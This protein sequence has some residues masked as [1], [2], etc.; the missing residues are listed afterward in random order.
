ML[1]QGQRLSSLSSVVGLQST[2][3]FLR[4]APRWREPKTSSNN[5]CRYSRK[6]KEGQ[7]EGEGREGHDRT[8]RSMIL[9][10]LLQARSKSLETCSSSLT[11][12]KPHLV[13]L[14][15]APGPVSIAPS[16]YTPNT[17]A[18]RLQLRKRSMDSLCAFFTQVELPCGDL[19]SVPRMTVLPHVGEPNVIPWNRFEETPANQKAQ[20]GAQPRE[21]YQSHIW[22]D[23]S[24]Q[25]HGDSPTVCSRLL[26]LITRSRAVGRC[27]VRS[28]WKDRQPAVKF[29]VSNLVST[30]TSPK[31]R[32]CHEDV[33][34][35][36]DDRVICEAYCDPML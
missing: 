31:S 22:A 6:P 21:Q 29:M 35:S 33:R 8:V 16:P 2:L 19:H 32:H 17:S 25:L 23:L 28:M 3:E 18:M 1:Q 12:A 26:T 10:L 36:R 14:C 24:F 34:R 5:A 30:T 7:G 27:T 13:C 20:K 11:R 15:R 9:R 4:Q